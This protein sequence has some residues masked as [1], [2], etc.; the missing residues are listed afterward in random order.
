[1]R[2]CFKQMQVQC[3]SIF[4][5]CQME[6]YMTIKQLKTQLPNI[7]KLIG[8][9]DFPKEKDKL[10][11]QSFIR[12]SYSQE[13]PEWQHNQVLEFIGDS[14]LD[15]YFV[16]LLCS[17]EFKNYGSFNN[18]AQFI[19]TKDEGELTKIKSE[20]VNGAS[21]AK[22]IDNLKLAQYLILG[23]ADE[24]NNVRN[25]QATKEDLFEAIV[26][27]VAL[28]YDFDKNIIK[29]V[30]GKMLE[31]NTSGKNE[32]KQNQRLTEMRK[33]VGNEKS[34]NEENSVGKLL[35]LS[36]NKYIPTPVYSYNSKPEYY[37]N[38][39]PMWKCWC[40]IENY[41]Y[42]YYCHSTSKK[43]AKQWISFHIL[44]YILG[45]EKE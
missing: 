32:Q 11:I 7:K 6:V 13:H 33:L 28:A 30:C 20:Y 8:C 17:P 45:Y 16:R 23:G 43:E 38:G 21:L 5:L 3:A 1:M 4:V 18:S 27:A 2:L 15:S 9:T 24:N 14:V 37:D 42:D 44:K 10:L 29:N 22:H 12:R 25:K 40:K 31:L 36:Q 41:K 19:S 26:G 39:N 35:L 34:I